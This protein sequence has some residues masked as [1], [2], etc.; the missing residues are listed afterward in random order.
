[1]TSN[2]DILWDDDADMI[3]D[4]AKILFTAGGAL[5]LKNYVLHHVEEEEQAFGVGL[6]QEKHQTLN[7]SMRCTHIC[8][9]TSLL[10]VQLQ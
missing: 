6:I 9:T 10:G 4:K 3:I 1:M 2:M 7:K 5:A 8:C